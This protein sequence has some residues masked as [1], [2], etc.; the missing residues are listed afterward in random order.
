VVVAD[1]RTGKRVFQLDLPRRLYLGA[2]PVFLGDDQIVLPLDALFRRP[3]DG[4]WTFNYYKIATP[5]EC[6]QTIMGPA[7]GPDSTASSSG[8]FAYRSK[9]QSELVVFDIE[10]RKMVFR[11]PAPAAPP[12]K[13][14]GTKVPVIASD[15]RTVV[16]PSLGLFEVDSGRALWWPGDHETIVASAN[17]D[18]FVVRENWSTLWSRMA[19]KLQ[20]QTIAFR[21][22]DTGELLWRTRN[23]LYVSPPMRNAA[24]TLVV[25]ADGTVRRM[26]LP[27]H[28]P[29]LAFC[30]SILAL[31]L[32]SLWTA[33]WWLRRR[34][35]RGATAMPPIP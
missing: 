12:S 6:L 21:R 10:R 7:I 2:P 3:A 13:T 23:G 26:P 5:A 19:P 32:V 1:H 8:R 27:V 16:D 30:Q 34:R 24:G 14:A 4:L 28:W 11:E 33:L 15:G 31:P 29:L 17:A 22:L 18:H 9:D 35:L 25:M 20:F